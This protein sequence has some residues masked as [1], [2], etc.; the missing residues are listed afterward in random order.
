MAPVY[1]IIADTSICN[2]NKILDKSIGLNAVM[3]TI[4][5]SIG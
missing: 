3:P 1:P 2:N 4:N 5:G